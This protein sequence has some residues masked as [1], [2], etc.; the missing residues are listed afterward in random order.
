MQF[1]FSENMNKKCDTEYKTKPLIFYDQRFLL[2][3]KSGG[4]SQKH[5]YSTDANTPVISTPQSSEYPL[6]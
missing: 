5:Y 4:I 6:R 3:R 2:F 1:L